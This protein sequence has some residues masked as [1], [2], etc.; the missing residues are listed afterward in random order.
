MAELENVRDRILFNLK[1]GRQASGHKAA[2]KAL[3]RFLAELLSLG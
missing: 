1:L 2:Q 3:S